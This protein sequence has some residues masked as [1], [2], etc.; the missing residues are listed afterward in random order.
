MHH[1][2][3]VKASE[4]QQEAH[5]DTQSQVQFPIS[6]LLPLHTNSALPIAHTI[7]CFNHVP[8]LP[9]PLSGKMPKRVA[10]HLLTD[11]LSLLVLSMLQ[12][13]KEYLLTVCNKE[14]LKDS[15][16]LH[17]NTHQQTQE[18]VRSSWHQPTNY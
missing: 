11:P 6:F 12:T 1:F 9:P 7:L 8:G 18:S 10:L 3:Q 4:H 14:N 15:S 16:E 5:L 13:L 17:S 2:L